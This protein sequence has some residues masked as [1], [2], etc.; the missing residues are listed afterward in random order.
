MAKVEIY[1]GLYYACNEVRQRQIRQRSSNDKTQM[2]ESRRASAW[3]CFRYTC[4]DNQQE[5]TLILSDGV[6]NVGTSTFL[7]DHR[8]RDIST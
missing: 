3:V 1:S 7:F 2:S 8:C 6:A 5:R 4:D